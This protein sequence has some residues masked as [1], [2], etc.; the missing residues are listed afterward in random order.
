VLV[1]SAVFASGVITPSKFT[2]NSL[3]I[4]QPNS[5]G[6]PRVFVD[7]KYSFKDY[8]LQPV[9]SKFT[10]NINISEA[11]DLYCWQ[12]NL[13][14]TKSQTNLDVLSVNRIIANEF[15]AR[16]ASQTSSESLGIVINS[17]DNTKRTSGFAET[18]LG[19]ASGV[20][21]TTPGRLVSI[22]FNVIG[23]GSVNLGISVTGNLA[24]TLLDSNG[25]SITFTTTNGYFT[26]KLTGDINGDRTV[27]GIDFGL[28]AKAFGTTSVEA[29]LNKDGS[30]DG[31]DF[32]LFAKNFGRSV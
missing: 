21:S 3:G 20:S 6:T 14:W 23:Y 9:G 13:T 29:D 10:V 1:V 24:T 17:T 7:P 28:F 25:A 22:E 19:A 4:V 12:I 5:P 8:A 31:V 26:N 27:D 11:T 32:G 16:S 2:L 15:L 18:L 30:V